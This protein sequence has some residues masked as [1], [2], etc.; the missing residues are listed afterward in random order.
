M[1]ETVKKIFPS[2]PEVPAFNMEALPRFTQVVW[3]Q[4]WCHMMSHTFPA[5][6][7]MPLIS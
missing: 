1:I 4:V 7:M 2:L 6:P 5:T 3:S